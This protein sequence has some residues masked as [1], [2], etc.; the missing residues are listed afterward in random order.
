MYCIV[1][2][3]GMRVPNKKSSDN[4][5]ARVATEEQQ[6]PNRSSQVQ[7]ELQQ[8]GR[9]LEREAQIERKT[10]IKEVQ[11]MQARQDAK[12]KGH[13]QN[14]PRSMVTSPSKKITQPGRQYT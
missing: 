11:G 1:K 7:N 5:E 3:A 4:A 13:D 2:V 6:Q 10:H 14:P 8:A 12:H 9:E